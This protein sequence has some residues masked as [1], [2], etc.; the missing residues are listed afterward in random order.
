[1]SNS[2]PP[3]RPDGVHP[4]A[5]PSRSVSCARRPGLLTHASLSADAI[6]VARELMTLLDEPELHVLA[7]RPHCRGECGGAAC[8]RHATTRCIHTAGGD[9]RSSRR[10]VEGRTDADV[11]RLMTLGYS[12][13]RSIMACVINTRPL[14][15]LRKRAASFSG[16]SPTTSPAGITAPRS[17]TTSRS[18]APRPISA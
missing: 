10:V 11:Q 2:P 6:G 14:A 18:R 17:M 13:S 4:D 9:R 5:P 15:V 8:P 3:V 1:M 16:S 12:G 7:S